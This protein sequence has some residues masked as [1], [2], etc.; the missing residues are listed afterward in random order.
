MRMEWQL[1]SPSGVPQ[2]RT[3]IMNPKPKSLEG[4]RVLLQWNGKNNGDVFLSRIGEILEREVKGVKI[5]KNWEVAID[6]QRL[7]HSVKTSQSFAD[8]LIK[9]RPDISIGSQ[10]D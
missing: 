3:D 1:V 6:T 5:I 2:E 9:F 4:K 7:S 10:C 8:Q